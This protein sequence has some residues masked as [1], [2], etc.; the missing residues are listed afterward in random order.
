M[1]HIACWNTVMDEDRYMAQTL[2]RVH[3]G[4]IGWHAD[5]ARA[6]ACPAGIYPGA[7][8]RGGRR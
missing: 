3:R 4:L 8:A 2:E 1:G 6:T 7:A 5:S